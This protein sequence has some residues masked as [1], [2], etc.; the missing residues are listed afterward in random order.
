MKKQFL[1]R[2]LVLA[3]L[4]TG[5][6]MASAHAAGTKTVTDMMGVKTEVPVPPARIADLWFAHNELVV[7][8]GGA[9]SIAM[10]VDR[11]SM[12]PWM[13]RIAPILHNAEQLQG[14]TPTPEAL[15]ASH[16]DLVFAT[17]Q[18]SGLDVYRRANIPAVGVNFHDTEGLLRCLDLTADVLGTKRA[19][20]IAS[21]YRDYLQQT[22]SFLSSQLSSISEDARP[23]VLHILSLS[24]LKI[25]GS[26]T[27]IDEWLHLA[28]GRNVA[29]AING[30]KQAVSLEQ[31]ASWNPDVIIL[32]GAAGKPDDAALGPVWQSLKA[33]KAGKV[34]RNP[35]GVFPWDRY[36]TELALQLR[37]A[38]TVL[39]PELFR[40]VDM[41]SET[42]M[43][44][45]RFFSYDLTDEEARRI[46]AALPPV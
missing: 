5:A 27:I 25:D 39:H 15:L 41:L 24:P 20:D 16:I 31:I 26:G 36:G 38:A 42:K 1:K 18:L 10:T 23:R 6:G 46:L 28:G 9:P 21:D 11:E 14:T 44:Y 29:A 40:D 37:W 13:Y 2:A 8:L 43:F 19:H 32:G 45:R 30:S 17:P 4:T 12:A 35:A 34:F 22:E 3:C 7:M 33:V